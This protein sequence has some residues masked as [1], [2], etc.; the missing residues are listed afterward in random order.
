MNFNL[1]IVIDGWNE[2]YAEFI[3]QLGHGML[4]EDQSIF[5]KCYKQNVDKVYCS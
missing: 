3:L 2:H 4:K 1:E 5:F